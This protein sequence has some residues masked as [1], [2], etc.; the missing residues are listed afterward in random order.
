MIDRFASS[1]ADV[2]KERAV[3]EQR[4]TSSSRVSS[5]SRL[6][7]KLPEKGPKIRYVVSMQQPAN[8]KATDYGG[9]ASRRYQNR[10][11]GAQ[12]RT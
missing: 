11:R 10:R 12:D 5:P 8:V 7:L 1:P 6:I 3:A 4:T 2:Q 9:Q